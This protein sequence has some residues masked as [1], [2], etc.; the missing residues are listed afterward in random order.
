MNFV[1]SVISTFEASSTVFIIIIIIMLSLLLLLFFFFFFF[2]SSTSSYHG[3]GQPVT[4]SG[5][6]HPE[7]YSLVFPNSISWYKPN[8][9]R[10]MRQWR[11]S[12]SGL[13]V[14]SGMEE[15]P[16]QI[17]PVQRR[18]L[19]ILPLDLFAL[20][21]DRNPFSGNSSYWQVTQEEARRIIPSFVL[22]EVKLTCL[23]VNYEDTME[24]EV[25]TAPFFINL[26]SGWW[27]IWNLKS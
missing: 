18:K 22:D 6:I 9:C 10:K 11:P 2:S 12:H 23:Y 7:G 26:D 24:N 8:L 14:S 15:M 25:L 13:T 17:M 3:F 4:H 27:W 5:Y 16:S 19:A 21:C 20:L 1:K